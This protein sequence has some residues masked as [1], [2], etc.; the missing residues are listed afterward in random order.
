MFEREADRLGR[1]PPVLE[2]ND[3][4]ARPGH[5]LERLCVALDIPYDQAM[6]SWPAGR[7]STDGVW[8]PAWY[9]AVERS[10]GFGAPQSAE[11]KPLPDALQRVADA[12]QPH[13][14]VLAAHRLD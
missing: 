10:T 9:D 6:L 4:L 8:A 5:M 1:A 13:Y 7:R 12:A 2:G 14:Q 11:R 3:V